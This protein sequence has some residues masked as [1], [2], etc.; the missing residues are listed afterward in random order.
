MT[1]KFRELIKGLEIKR[2]GV[3]TAFYI[4]SNG[5]YN[6]FWGVNGYNN[7]IMVGRCAEDEQLYLICD[8]ADKIDFVHL[9]RRCTEIDIPTEY[10]VVHIWFAEPISI[11]YS[12]PVANLFG[13]GLANLF[14]YGDEENDG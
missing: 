6:G 3:F 9:V 8:Q 5:F 1:D 2:K 10:D 14:G 4:A 7:I 11:D 12:I 13:Y